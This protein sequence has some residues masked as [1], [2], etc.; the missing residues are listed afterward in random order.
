V[1]PRPDLAPAFEK[2]ARALSLA[3]GFTLMPVAV[4]GPDLAWALAA[5]LESRGTA[6]RVVE[7]LDELGW[8]SLVANILDGGTRPPAADVRNAESEPRTGRTGGGPE[9]THFTEAPPPE[10]VVLVIGP[11]RLTQGMAAG[12][13]LANQRRDTIVDELAC[14]LLWCGPLDF[15]NATWER[16]PDLW[17]IRGMAY[18]VEAE[19]RAPAESPLW[20]GVVA[21]EAPERLRETLRIARE[22]G[23]REVVARLAVQLAESLLASSEYVEAGEVIEEAWG[24]APLSGRARESLVLL[25][26][27]AATALGDGPRA[28]AALNDAEAMAREGARRDSLSVLVA[29]ARGNL[30]LGESAALAKG[31][32]EEALEAARAS[33]DKR[34]EAVALADLGIAE[35]ALG[36]ATSALTRL[37][38]ARAILRDGGDERS[39]ARSL[40]HL[41]RA[42]AALYDV[43][44]AA[45]CFEEALELVRGQGDRRGEARVLCHVARA[46][47]DAGD[48]EKAREDALRA[49]MLARASEDERLIARAEAVLAEA[50]GAG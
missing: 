15:L 22:Q 46:Y 11:R 33:G 14:P 47:L 21:R 8:R 41:G 39:E 27:R 45:A 16:A 18:H 48:A 12:L 29:T 20:A 3:G 24:D 7:P 10:K 9:A 34:N 13:S 26:T 6:A 30:A 23:D 44:A 19:A 50:R 43:R 5:W 38:E 31:A 28:R 17:S 35:L 1:R 4:T 36:E 40:L 32:Y 2:I 49:L 42:H 37:E 25:R